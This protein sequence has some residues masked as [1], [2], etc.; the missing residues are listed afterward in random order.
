L[1]IPTGT[2]RVARPTSRI[3]LSPRV[4]MREIP[5]SQASVRATS[6]EMTAPEARVADP[7]VRAMRVS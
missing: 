2:V 5:A 3:S 1:A 4:M 7:P 6:P